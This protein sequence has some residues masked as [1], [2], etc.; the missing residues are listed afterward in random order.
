MK[1]HAIIMKSDLDSFFELAD[2]YGLDI[3]EKKIFFIDIKYIIPN[4]FDF[5]LWAKNWQFAFDVLS[6]GETFLETYVIVVESVD[7]LSMLT[8]EQQV[9]I[10]EASIKLIP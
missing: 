6:N 3:E 8:T 10:T 9:L 4:T 2:S 5:R 7:Q 1:N